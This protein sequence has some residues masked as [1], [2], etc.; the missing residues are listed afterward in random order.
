[1]D[2]DHGS[3]YQV[4]IV[5]ANGTEQLS[6]WM[7]SEEQIP[8][9]MATVHNSPGKTYWLQRR[10]VVCPDCLDGEETIL[11]FP[12]LLIPS[13]RCQPRDARYAHW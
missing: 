13:R 5:L 11:E 4:R 12:L 1:M 7:K 10:N 9:V 3:E 6:G 2:H 8:D